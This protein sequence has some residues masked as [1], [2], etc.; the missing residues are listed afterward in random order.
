MRN[1]NKWL[2]CLPV[3]A[4]AGTL[5]AGCTSSKS[6][7]PSPSTSPVASAVVKEEAASPGQPVDGGT[8]T[9]STFSDIVSVN[10]IYVQDT[11]SGDLQDLL[12]ANL[13]DL[14][15]KANLAVEPWSL[16]AELPKVSEDGKTYTIKLKSSAKWTDGH[17]V[18][19]DDIL[20]TYNTMRNP[21]AGSPLINQYDKIDTITKKDDFTVE[22]KL[23]QVYAPFQYSLFSPLA[24]A[25]ILK[26]V[27]IKDLQ[28]NTFGKDP[29][30]TVTNGPWKWSEWTQKQHI[31]L[32]AYPDY[33]AATK[34]HIQKIVYKNY[35]DQNTEVQALMKG[36]TDMSQAIP[37]TQIEAVKKKENL[38][39]ILEPGPQYEYMAFNFDPKNFPDN[40]VPF[41]G[42]KTRQAIA[43]ALNRQGMVDNVLKGSGKLMNAPFLPGSWADPGDAAVNYKYDAEK[44]KSLLK[45]DGWVTGSDGILAKDGHRFSFEL[46]YNAGNSRREQVAAV[47]QQ[48]LKDVGIE[49]KPK[50]IDFSSWID[51][52]VTPGKF[53]AILLS[54]SLT[55]PDPDGENIFSSKYFPPTG[56]NVGWYKNEKLDKL[57]VDGYSTVDQ[58]ARKKIYTEVGKEISTDLPYVFLYQYGLPQVIN[59]TTVH[60]ADADK[61]ES[62]L[63]YG[64]LFH[65]INWWVDKK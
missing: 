47:I 39:V 43:N 36:D 46:Q 63:A 7:E 31:T 34:P 48:N 40:Y 27:P 4:L 5:L 23:K 59:S 11:A 55:N 58:S 57:W 28:N 15:R 3:F 26:D 53:P 35:A 51:Q 62:S 44:A 60:Y 65:I 38:K 49:V 45:E 12:F 13:Y 18:T 22:I 61:P 10:P 9:I 41:T 64:Y 6:T 25:H 30:K 33:W 42:Q 54:W 19:A 14:D 1:L 29:A 24:P 52:N 2:T 21:D 8:F 37:V 32:E 16:A 20:F 17:A 56:Q 50:G